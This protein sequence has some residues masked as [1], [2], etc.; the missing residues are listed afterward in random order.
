MRIHLLSVGRR[1]PAWVEAGFNDYARRLPPECALRLIEIDPGRRGKGSAAQ[2]VA[3][4][5][6]RLLKSVPK[7]AGII[8]LERRGAAWST[9]ELADQ[10]RRWLGSGRD[11]ALLIGG[12]DGLAQDCL[13]RAEQQ[14]SLSPLTL[15]HQL[16]RVILAEQLYRAWSLLQSH[17]YHRA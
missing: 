7:G 11:W 14:W 16:V 15:P 4:E 10:L 9:E 13:D 3:I 12:A 1:M 6:Q 8:A 17:P 2:A 5:G